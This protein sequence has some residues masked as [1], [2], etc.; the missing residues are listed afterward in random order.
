[1]PVQRN[2]A[3]QHQPRVM[4]DGTNVRPIDI[5]KH[6][7]FAFSFEVTTTLTADAVFNIQAA[8]PSSSNPCNPGTFAAVPEVATCEGGA[9]AAQAT[10]TIPSGTEAGTVCTGTIPCRN[11]AFIQL[12]SASGQTNNV[13]VAGV[14]S[15]PKMG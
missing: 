7:G 8:P 9:E 14:L 15:G 4:W 11:G 10:V 13:L 1:M 5:R 12:V 2:Y 6:V 3:I